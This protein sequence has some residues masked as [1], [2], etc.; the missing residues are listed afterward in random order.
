MK[1]RRPAGTRNVTVVD[2]PASASTRQKARRRLA[3]T[4]IEANSSVK[5]SWTTSVPGRSPVFVVVTEICRS[6]SVDPA[7]TVRADRSQVVYD[8]PWPNGNN[9]STG[10]SA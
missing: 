5:K 1:P 9:G 8:S 7:S 10:L 4:P 3:G 6:S 2:S